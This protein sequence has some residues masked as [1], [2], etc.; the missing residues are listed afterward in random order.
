LLKKIENIPN[1]SFLFTQHQMPQNCAALFQGYHSV[2]KIVEQ[3][4]GLGE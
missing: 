1:Q 4:A 2:D 3:L